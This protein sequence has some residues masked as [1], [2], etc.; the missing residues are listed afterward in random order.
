MNPRRKFEYLV[1]FCLRVVEIT[2]GVKGF[3]ALISKM[4]YSLGRFTF[5]F[6]LILSAFKLSLDCDDMISFYRMT[7]WI[8]VIRFNYW[9]WTTL[10]PLRV[11][12]ITRNKPCDYLTL[13]IGDWL[14]VA[15][16][17]KLHIIVYIQDDTKKIM[18][19]HVYGIP[20]EL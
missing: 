18:F 19:W 12:K 15:P 16:I 2:R 10:F 8:V 9:A 13:Q 5:K 6:I 1:K 20:K 3:T 11:E 4:N 14:A 17:V 7:F